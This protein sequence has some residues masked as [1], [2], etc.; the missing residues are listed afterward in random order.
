METKIYT[1]GACVGNPGPGGWAAI[2][3]TN[4]EKK[5]RKIAEKNKIN[6]FKIGTTKRNYLNILR[7]VIRLVIQVQL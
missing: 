3:L 6:L 5:V 1:D 2:I 4:N 7:R